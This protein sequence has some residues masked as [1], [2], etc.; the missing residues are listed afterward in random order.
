MQS[1]LN[2]NISQQIHFSAKSIVYRA[3]RERDQQPVIIKQLKSDFPTAAE[4][5]R[6]HHEFEILNQLTMP[7]VIRIY[8]WQPYQKGLVLIIEDFG[9]E[10]LNA[11]LKQQ[12]F[13]LPILLSLLIQTADCLGQIHANNLIHKDINPNNI[14]Y[15]LATGQMKLIDFGLASRLPRE[16]P[17]LQSPNQL[18]GTLAYLSPEQTGRMNR[19]L[20]YRTDLYSL[21]VTFYELLT[22]RLPFIS[23]DPLEIVHSHIAKLPVPV[24]EINPQ[25]PII[26]S[27]VVMKLMAKNAE[28]RYQSAFGLKYDLEQILANLQQLEKLSNFKLAQQD[29]SSKFHLPQ[30]LYGRETEIKTLL[31]VFDGM[32]EGN[33]KMVLVAGY[34]GIGKSLLV[35]EIYK[36][37]SRTKGYFVTGKFD[38][39]QRNVPYTAIVSAFSE[40]IQQLLAED[41]KSLSAWRNELSQALHPNGQVIID[42]IPE[43]E[44]VIGPQPPVPTLGSIE[45]QNRFTLVFQNFVRVFSQPEHPLVIFFDD[46]QWVDSATLKL[47]EV[48]MLDNAPKTLL[49]I[50]AY[51]D[52]EVSSSHPL[53]ITLDT[54][55]KENIPL[56]Q[57]ILK[58]LAYE[59]INQLIAD[60]LQQTRQSVELLTDLVMR[61]TGGN[62]FF[63]N[64]FL[65]TLYEENLLNFVLPTSTNKGGWQ[66]DIT[67]IETL[68]ITDNI[69]D[70]M[71]NKLRKLPMA[72]Q[73]VLR[74][75][76]C[77]GNHFDLATLSIIYEK[78]AMETFQEVVPIITEG[79]ILPTTGL[80]ISG[81]TTTHHSQFRFLHDRV[82][83]AAYSLINDAQKQAVH[84]KIGR[85]L[86]ANTTALD[87]QLF[88]IVD[89]LNEGISLISEETERLGLAELN[90][91][92]GK[93]AKESIA[94]TSSIQYLKT[95]IQLLPTNFWQ[96]HY[97]LAFT[98]HWE[99]TDSEF[100]SSNFAVAEQLTNE[101]STQAA[102][103]VDK[104]KLYHL[105]IELY[106][107]QAEYLRCVEICLDALH[108]LN[109]DLPPLS[110]I[111]ADSF[112]PEL[113][114]FKQLLGDRVVDSLF[115]LPEM[116]DYRAKE[117]L[118]L[119][120][121]LAGIAVIGH[122][123]F[124]LLLTLIGVNCS[125]QYG[126]S[127]DSAFVYV[128]LGAIFITHF[129]DHIT[130]HHLAR[131]GI[132]LIEE[133]YPDPQL[134]TKESAFF[135]W[136]IN[137]WM[138][139]PRT[140]L[141]ISKRGLLKAMECGDLTFATYNYC[142]SP[143]PLFFTGA[144]LDELIVEADKIIEFCGANK[145]TFTIAIALTLI[146]KMVALNLQGKTKDYFSFS[147]Q[148]QH[149][150]VDESQFITD[151]E[152]VPMIVGTFYIRKFQSL[153]LFKEYEKALSHMP[154]IDRNFD[155]CGGHLVTFEYHFYRALAILALHSNY[156]KIKSDYLTPL[157]A[158]RDFVKKCADQCPS[159]FLFFQR[160]LE[161]ETAR[162]QGQDLEAMDLYDQAIAVAKENRF[163][164]YEG[165][166]NELAA[167]F[168]LSKGKTQFAAIYLYEAHYAYQLW[169]ATA[170]VLQL[171]TQYSPLL[172]KQPTGTSSLFHSQITTTFGTLDSNTLGSTQE[173]D[174]NSIIKASQA[175]SGEIVLHQ[176]L[177]QMIHI[178]IENAGAELGYLL[179]PKQQ[180]WVIE[181][182]GGRRT[183]AIL[184]S[185]PIDDNRLV[186]TA[187]IY[188]VA[189]TQQWI[190]LDNATQMG[191]FT[192]DPHIIESQVKSLLCLPLKHQGQLTAILY[193]ENNLAAGAFT[194]KQ[195]K[196]LN[197]LS[198]QLAISIENAQLYANL[199]QKVVERT[200]ELA[201]KNERLVQLDQE[202]NEF[203]GIAAHD[204][205]N[206]LSTILGLSEML[207]E[208]IDVLPVQTVI[209][210]AT[211]ISI[212]ARQMF[213]LIVNLLDVNQIESGKFK[214][215]WQAVDLYK[216]IQQILDSYQTR[217]TAKQI[218]LHY[219]AQPCVI[220]LDFNI[221][222]Q[223]L[224]NV[225]SNAI[226]Y[227][228][229]EKNVYIRLIE[230]ETRV[231][232]E[233]QD[234]G[235]GLS[236]TDRQ[237]LF[238]KFARLTAQP[239]KGEH[240][241]GLGLFI[242]KKLVTT[243]NGQVWCES[244]LGKGATFI[245]EFNKMM[246]H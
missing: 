151:W 191:N 144:P 33:A 125:L 147:Y 134:I 63:V 199:E 220:Q 72:S 102:S 68:D 153:C 164:N 132:R 1:I 106:G 78:P 25:I 87:E 50:G 97:E 85:L 123:N 62:P 56:T 194:S 82:Q 189:R 152:F 40:L 70:L 69:V 38:Q 195:L 192:Q 91:K 160:L 190:T 232:C 196:T 241:T 182:Q 74:L 150:T 140:N 13:T 28:E 162:Y 14:I 95:A 169:G 242:V 99:W 42:V 157:E 10:S 214:I 207:A 227:S 219:Q 155:G 111:T 108:L 170:K 154:V 101:L 126:N 110:K 27:N 226:K 96:T 19:T 2:Y 178:V 98:L 186:S 4:L 51:R 163:I 73:K 77:V 197:L 17:T 138:A 59:Q 47:L 118:L 187:V 18:E 26:L 30:K 210:F 120:S 179:F 245:I 36:S 29:I 122:P 143:P 222:R 104:L 171:Q 172:T 37:L 75:A 35:K 208:D 128:L 165:L 149:E 8:E 176:L 15:N 193:L 161:A 225:I 49:L 9:G 229:L 206:P 136:H 237:K 61:K 180:Q 48:M 212:S 117:I 45:S 20:D 113:E 76:A 228:P 221:A 215:S 198:S 202:K 218:H 240:S 22:G 131:M 58:P 57:I 175:L 211:N 223:I 129:R 119:V 181:A 39:F 159:N 53:M 23:Q 203:L 231:R 64:Q 238:G 92:A 114:K 243:M 71:V 34:S 12:S 137:H 135:A 224:D 88:N 7:G 5:A 217:A 79:F 16:N 11:I 213:D 86:L 139:D 127:S 174:L 233:I 115:E 93:K 66:W 24:A 31:T 146:M 188:Y 205:K 173:L 43:V 116:Q 244:E 41:D 103:T 32:T 112:L 177:K 148:D 80:E 201:E 235:P 52:N 183:T 46:L 133:K 94:Y 44:L 121:K 109:I 236:E 209:N 184:Q 83:Q 200:H 107:I 124:Y 55:H 158:S 239:T 216:L 90:L 60:S 246:V 54:F 84:L 105:Q 89:Q 166:A 230:T 185:I 130:G 156:H 65:H 141:D 3:I 167:K 21:G 234:E 67:Q 81:E 100:R 142:V 145:L 6:Y 168:Y 204:L